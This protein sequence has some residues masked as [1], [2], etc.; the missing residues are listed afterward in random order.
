MQSYTE[1]TD[2]TPGDYFR[3]G[4]A[5]LGAWIGAAGV[6]LSWLGMAIAGAAVVLLAI[7]SFKH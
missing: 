6:V 7:L 2:R 3:F 5:C 1:S 4:V